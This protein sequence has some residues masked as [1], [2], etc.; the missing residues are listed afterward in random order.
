[1]GSQHHLGLPHVSV[2]LR[3]QT[4]LDFLFGGTD[5]CYACLPFALTTSACV[6]C[7]FSAVPA[8]I[9]RRRRLV[10]AL[11]VYVTSSSEA[12]PRGALRGRALQ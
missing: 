5:Y 9:M 10:D 4:L 7:L 11:I 2:H 8:A 12:S 3:H 1:M 6:S